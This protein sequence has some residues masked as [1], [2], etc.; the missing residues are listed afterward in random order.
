VVGKYTVELVLEFGQSK[1]K[2]KE[3]YINQHYVLISFQSNVD[4]EGC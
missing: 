4:W 3:Q 1:D 2:Q